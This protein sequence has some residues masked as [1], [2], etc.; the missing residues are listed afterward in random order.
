MKWLMCILCIVLIG[1]VQQETMVEYSEPE[2]EVAS[3]VDVW[4]YGRYGDDAIKAQFN[5]NE[6]RVFGKYEVNNQSHIFVGYGENNV[7]RGDVDES[8]MLFYMEEQT[9]YGVNLQNHKLLYISDYDVMDNISYDTKTLQGVYQLPDNSFYI[10]QQIHI[11]VLLDHLILVTFRAY[12]NEM[13]HDVKHIGTRIDNGFWLPELDKKLMLTE[14]HELIVGDEIYY[15]HIQIRKPSLMDLN[16]ASSPEEETLMLSV[17]GDYK[18]KIIEVGYGIAEEKDQWILADGLVKIIKND[19]I[20]FWL[21]KDLIHEAEHLILTNDLFFESNTWKGRIVKVPVLISGYHGQMFG[22]LEDYISEGYYIRDQIEEDLN[23]DGLKDLILILDSSYETE[24]LL[25]VLLRRDQGFE[26]S[27]LSDQA[28][29]NAFIDYEDLMFEDHHLILS[30]NDANNHLIREKMVFDVLSDY[31]LIKIT[32]T[33]YD[34]STKQDIIYEYDMN[35]Y[36][37]TVTHQQVENFKKRI[38]EQ[39]YLQNYNG[40]YNKDYE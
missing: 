2:S 20:S 30:V 29:N 21:D 33:E 35:N 5:V 17:L 13:V 11:D 32:R 37:V 28:V 6:D 18:D 27:L 9:L 40:Q 24:R 4:K 8:P 3:T 7:F 14:N 34:I 38:K 15:E 19:H 16:I 23:Q 10:G 36:N 25:I 39:I 12:D 22:T 26:L 31:R 1:C